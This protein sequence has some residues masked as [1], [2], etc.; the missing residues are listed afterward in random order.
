MLHLANM[1]RMHVPSLWQHY[2]VAMAMSLNKLE[3]KVQI[4]HLHVRCFHMVTR[5]RKSVQ[6]IQRYST[7]YTSFLTNELC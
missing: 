3:N 1:Q 5:L 6:Y 7:K 2:L 4:H